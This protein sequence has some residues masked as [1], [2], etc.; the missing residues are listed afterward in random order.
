MEP[1]LLA[2]LPRTQRE[3]VESAGYRVLRWSAAREVLQARVAKG[4][5]PAGLGDFLAHWLPPVIPSVGADDLQLEF[6]LTP[7]QMHLTGGGGTLG[8][9]P[10][11]HALLHLPALRS[12]WSRELRLNHFEALRAV[13]PKAWVLDDAMV[14]P[15]A[16]IHGLDLV[17]WDQLPLGC[18]TGWEIRDQTGHVAADWHQALTSRHCVLAFV[19]PAGTKLNARYARNDKGQ[20]VLRSVEASS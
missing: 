19:K 7:D 18:K 9:F 1:N 20:V 17:S 11:E 2:S 16:V 15:G 3:A 4:R 8:A 5:L 12:F 10:V 14:P 6:N 13:V